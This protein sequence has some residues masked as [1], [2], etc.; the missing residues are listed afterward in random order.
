MLTVDLVNNAHDIIHLVVLEED[1]NKVSL[2]D[3]LQICLVW[4]I[5][6]SSV[7]RLVDRVVSAII[8]MTIYFL[9]ELLE[10]QSVF[11]IIELPDV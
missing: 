6:L 8:F 4:P 9:I 7:P 1:F 10:G 5:K 2:T 3:G 11:L